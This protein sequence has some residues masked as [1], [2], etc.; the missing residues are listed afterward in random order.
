MCFFSD[1]IYFCFT[2][3]KNGLEGRNVLIIS[4]PAMMRFAVLAIIFLINLSILLVSNMV[5]VVQ[6]DH[7]L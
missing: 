4:I 1:I 6:L 2:V 3:V 5:K 7:F